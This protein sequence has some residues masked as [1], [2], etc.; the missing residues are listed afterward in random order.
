IIEPA[1]CGKGNFARTVLLELENLVTAFAFGHDVD[2]AIGMAFQNFY[3]TRGTTHGM[4]PITLDI[5]DAERRFILYSFINELLIAIF[6]NMQGNTALRKEHDAERK[7]GNTGARVNHVTKLRKFSGRP[8]KT[9]T[10]PFEWLRVF[11]H[12]IDESHL[13]NPEA[14]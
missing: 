1:D 12:S 13:R 6:K 11:F 9:H 14:R 2:L 5:I 3:N 10:I 4:K 8:S 7:D